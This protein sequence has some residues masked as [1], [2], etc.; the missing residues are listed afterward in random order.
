M[1]DVPKAFKLRLAVGTRDGPQSAV[2]EVFTGGKKS[3]VYVAN[4]HVA[5]QLKVSLHE[6]GVWRLAYTAEYAA[7]LKARGEGSED[8]LQARWQRP[9][10]ARPG[11]THAISVV[12]PV[13]ELWK[14]EP[15]LPIPSEVTWRR[16]PAP[17]MESHFAVFFERGSGFVARRPAGEIVAISPLPN[18]DNLWVIAADVRSSP[19]NLAR[20]EQSKDSLRTILPGARDRGSRGIIFGDRPDGARVYIDV[21]TGDRSPPG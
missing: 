3:D 13:A 1:D 12:V 4:R 16:A 15:P 9:P 21:Y 10:E 8:R 18:G 19:E 2:W 5:S 17:G 11:W 20:Y 14:P 6:S 7:T